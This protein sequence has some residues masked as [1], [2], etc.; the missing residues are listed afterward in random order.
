[1]LNANINVIGIALDAIGID[2]RLFNGKAAGKDG[3]ADV[4]LIGLEPMVLAFCS[5]M[6]FTS[7]SSLACS[8]SERGW[9]NSVGSRTFGSRGRFFSLIL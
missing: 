8:S 7:A 2:V 6:A 9:S 3:A 5:S 1:V 4:A